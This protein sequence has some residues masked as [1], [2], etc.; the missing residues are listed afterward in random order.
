MLSQQLLEAAGNP[1]PPVT[2]G[3]VRSASSH[4]PPMAGPPVPSKVGA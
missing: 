3:G 2:L 1:L 4:V